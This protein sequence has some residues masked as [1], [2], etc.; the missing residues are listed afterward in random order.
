MDYDIF[1]SYSR[2]DNT[3]QQVSQLVERIKADFKAFSGRE[4][5]V[6]FD[7][8]EIRGMDDWRHRILDGLKKSH[9]FLA[10][11]SPAYFESE[12]C[13]WEFNEYTKHEI[14]RFS[15]FEGVAPL[16]F[17]EVP[18]WEDKA[19]EQNCKTWV[20]EM[21]RRQHFDFRPWSAL[22]EEALRN[23]DVQE[24]MNKLNEQINERI[25]R[26]ER[27][28]QA[29]GNVDAHNPHFMGRKNELRRMREN[30]SLGR[31]G[32]LTAVHGLGGLGKTALAIEYAHAYADQYGGGRWQIRCEGKEDLRVLITELASP[33]DIEFSDEEKRKPDLQFQRVITKLDN[34]AK[35]GKPHNTL[36][37][38]D[39]VDR[40]KL[41]DSSQTQYLPSADWLHVIATTRLGNELAGNRNDRTFLAID[42]LTEND[43]VSLI[44]SYQLNGRFADDS[45]RQAAN[46]IVRLLGSFT[47]AVEAAAVYLGQFSGDVTCAGFLA[48]LKNEG[49]AGLDAASE[50][51]SG[52]VRHGEKRIGATLR[53][54]FE[55]LNEAEKLVLS[56]AALLPAEQIAVPWLRELVAKEFP[57][58]GKDAEPGYPDPWNTLLRK[59]I[60][61]R[62]FQVAGVTD[63]NDKPLIVRMHRLVQENLFNLLS[64]NDIQLKHTNIMFFVG[65]RIKELSNTNIWKN[66]VWELEPID[67]IVSEF[68]YTCL[69][70]II[71]G[72]WLDN[73]KIHNSVKLLNSVI[74]IK[75]SV[76]EIDSDYF[77]AKNNLAAALI[78]ISNLVE[79]EKLL[80]ESLKQCT[81][82]LGENNIHNAKIMH[83]L[84]DL[85][86]RCHKINEAELMLNK[87]L[88]IYEL[89]ELED[90]M[91]I[92]LNSLTL[93]LNKTERKYEAEPLIKR[94]LLI[95]EKLYG[96]NH[97]KVS[98]DLNSM[99]QVL[100][101]YSRFSEAIPIMRRALEIDQICFGSEHPRVAIDLDTLGRSLHANGDR[102]EA[103]IMIKRALNI[104][105]KCYGSDHDL[106]SCNLNNL[107]SII[108]DE[109]LENNN[110]RIDLAET[111]LY[112]ALNID[113]KIFGPKNPEIVIDLNN[114]AA[115]LM[116]KGE[117]D[118]A[119]ALINRSLNIMTDHAHNENIAHDYLQTAIN[120]YV[121]YMHLSGN[122]EYK[123]YNQLQKLKLPKSFGL[124][125][126]GRPL[127]TS[128]FQNVTGKLSRN[129]KC[130]CGSG[131]KYKK[132]CGA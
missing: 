18:G 126:M 51:G 52:D 15:S 77:I 93:L 30:V 53:P 115:L 109:I 68:G 87:A 45:E 73:G 20:A 78:N 70:N 9:L 13:E 39:N 82:L 95:D 129:A 100:I 55:L 38:L 112:R 63:A 28:R 66:D 76:N 118:K 41:I 2:R 1:I 102:E 72:Y 110:D 7:L 108:M 128:L 54:T 25:L 92:C 17:V 101:S 86:T 107:A 49:L 98:Q 48:R 29:I 37:I 8:E 117:M 46:E 79:A 44:E 122:S 96:P 24:R 19:F 11:L 103:E 36:L 81:G 59:L 85:Y 43:A 97:H 74:S 119:Y 61:L 5:I 123:I 40:P 6:F 105:E 127:T 114:I 32:V 116:Q 60:S 22:G 65:N 14:G 99:A 23:V 50:T 124:Q 94:A 67:Y 62:L 75:E 42:E 4:L 106:I 56:Y 16:Y 125:K 3:K 131:K 10:C 111:Y 12:Y 58:Y 31:V 90:K 33:L 89:L 91:A 120:S 34:L 57:E 69:M 35:A 27:A 88:K 64:S 84:G 83:N 121:I 80:N 26:G 130:P 113:E 21:R 47:L 71:A 104:N 132:C